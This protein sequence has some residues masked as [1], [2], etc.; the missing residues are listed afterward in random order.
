MKYKIIGYDGNKYQIIECEADSCEE[1]QTGSVAFF[2]D[3][4]IE[5]DPMFI[6]EGLPIIHQLVE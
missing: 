4:G 5:F 6:I 1:A 2:K 3:H